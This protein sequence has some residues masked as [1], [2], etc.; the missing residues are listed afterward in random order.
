M[1]LSPDEVAAIK[2]AAASAFGA[3]AVVRLFGS[4]VDDARRGGDIDLLI[5]VDAED[6]TEARA[7]DFRHRLFEQIEPQK[8]DVLF[9]ARGTPRS[10]FEALA[11]RDG[12]PL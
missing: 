3:G 9:V 4:R 11:L 6:A 10:A 7:D 8:V 1:R 2:A 12:V 5:E